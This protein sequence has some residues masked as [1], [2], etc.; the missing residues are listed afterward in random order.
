MGIRHDERVCHDHG[1]RGQCFSS[2]RLFFGLFLAQ[3]LFPSEMRKRNMIKRLV[4]S[5]QLRRCKIIR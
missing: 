5:I 4:T 3:V 1:V 2:G